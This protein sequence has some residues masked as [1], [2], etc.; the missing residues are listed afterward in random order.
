MFALLVLGLRA[1]TAL[2]AQYAPPPLQPAEPLKAVPALNSVPAQAPAQPLKPVSPLKPANPPRD[3]RTPPPYCTGNDAKLCAP[4]VK[5]CGD[6]FCSR[7]GD[8]ADEFGR[9]FCGKKG[10]PLMNAPYGFYWNYAMCVRKKCD[11]GVIGAPSGY[12]GTTHQGSETACI[13]DT[14]HKLKDGTMGCADDDKLKRDE[15]WW[16]RNDPADQPRC[17]CKPANALH[18]N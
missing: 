10:D 15:Q 9:P 18:G 12:N 17:T 8:K 13:P 3:P 16:R 1:S 7:Y 14:V 11:L 4:C 2:F 5:K 6:D